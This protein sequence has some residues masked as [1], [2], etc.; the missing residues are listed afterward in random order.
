MKNIRKKLII[1]GLFAFLF[2]GYKTISFF[3]S[4]FLYPPRYEITMSRV[5]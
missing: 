1:V 5:M 2:A 3:Y 4:E